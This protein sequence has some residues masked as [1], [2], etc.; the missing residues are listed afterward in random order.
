[1]TIL[2]GMTRPGP[3]AAAGI[4]LLA[5]TSLACVASAAQQGPANLDLERGELGK[6]PTGWI[7]PKY[8]AAAGYKVQLTDD[9]PKTGKRCALVSRDPK[10]NGP[11]VG[12]LV[13]SF[14]A[15]AY[16]GKRV[17][18]RAAVRAEVSGAG[19]Q[20][21]L[22]L[23]IVRKDQ[24][25]FLDD[26]NDRA[27]V[28]NEWRDYEICGDVAED[29]VS[30]DVGLMLVG[31]GRAWLDAVSFEVIG[32]AWNEPSRPLQGQ[33][34][35]NLVAFTKLLGYV[36][37]FHPS[38][39]AAATNWEWFAID[40]LQ[41]VEQAK[42]PGELAVRLEKLFQPI[43][44]SL[45][46]FPTE[47]APAGGAAV[48]PKEAPAAKFVAWYHFGVGMGDPQSIY[49]SQRV[50]NLQLLPLLADGK[51]SRL[52]DPGKPLAAALGAGVSCWLPLSLSTDDKGTLPRPAAPGAAPGWSRPQGFK[53]SGNDRTTRLAAV[54][55]TWTVL[56]HFY[57]Y[58]DAVKTDWPGEL[59]S[60]LTKAATDAD[61]R[62]FLDTLRRLVAG[63]H[64]GHA[65]VALKGAPAV[66]YPPL[67]WDWIEDRLVVTRVAAQ[68]AGGLKP[69]DVVLKV[70]GRPAAL[71]L[72]E[73][74]QLISGATPQLKRYCALLELAQGA[75]DS[76]ITLEVLAE[77][78]QA[79]VLC[80]HRT[81]DGGSFWDLELQRP[82][83]E[84]IK[85]GILYVNLDR[86]MQ[87][88][89]DEAVPRLAKAKGLLFDLRGYPQGFSGPIP[90]LIDKAVTSPLFHIPVTLFPDRQDV[91]F[92]SVTWQIA[93]KGPRFTA[94]V[95]YLTDGR[96]ISQAETY[97]GIVEH[98]K[99]ADIVGSAT[100]GTNGNIN[101]FTLPGGYRV[102]WTGMKVLK[103]DGSRHHGVGIQPTVPV[104]PTI[105]GVL[106]GRD[107]VLERALEV[108]SR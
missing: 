56:Q 99:L 85:P 70:N 63:L 105:A 62:A 8:S 19:N 52:P 86:I 38:D 57:P 46:V 45:R 41:A 16:R 7:Q 67:R 66:F 83:I 97:L 42:N 75:K 59:R 55:L 34:L 44:P 98:Y 87:K 90:H 51:S 17:R 20:A 95:A 50:S 74:E 27:I 9:R 88:E 81:L 31:N 49:K 10:D 40:G 96:T 1:M 77:S 91:A 36:R 28:Q 94:K 69:G 72:D 14:D 106:Q 39:E 82:K 26:M 104:V 4:V 12:K 73:Q 30:V 15:A 65:F 35:D 84:E 24:L 6:V 76:A 100:A 103:H 102:W 101:P 107:E 108:V 21:Q 18:L 47:K 2:R 58:F 71:A 61:E 54:A 32:K 48:P 64:D 78:G 22:W 89:F 25:G 68:G 33:A 29:A 60:A 79:Q 43:A 92:R 3:F 11:G 37:Y 53:P 23:L 5:L 13:Q 80:L 93:P